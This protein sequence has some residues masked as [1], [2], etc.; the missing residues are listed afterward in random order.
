MKKRK[1]CSQKG[2]TLVEV[3]LSTFVLVLVVGSALFALRQSQMMAEESRLRLLAMHAARTTLETIKD[4]ALASVTAI[5]TT[6]IV[7]EDLPNG[8]IEIT[9]NPTVLTG[10]TVATVTVTVTYTGPNNMPRTLE[11][12]TMRSIY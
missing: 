4:S 3:M 11:I 2:F 8:E 5:S 10:V 7:P 1:E 6:G 12:T 9:T